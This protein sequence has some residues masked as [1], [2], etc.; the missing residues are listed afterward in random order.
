MPL[1]MEVLRKEYKQP[2]T[3]QASVSSKIPYSAVIPFHLICD[4]SEGRSFHEYFALNAWQPFQT[5]KC[6]FVAH[7]QILQDSLS[8]LYH[9]LGS[10]KSVVKFVARRKI[11][12]IRITPETN[13]P[14]VT[15]GNPSY[16]FHSTTNTRS[17]PP[18]VT[19]NPQ[20]DANRKILQ[21][22]MKDRDWA[23]I[24]ETKFVACLRSGRIQPKARNADVILAGRILV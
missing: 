3:Q 12:R 16:Y 19:T 18:F 24:S 7:L 5:E 9:V 22:L 11:R 23:E 8:L 17:S 15:R 21:E 6:L 14:A 10:K 4:G 2:I 1:Q 20:L 13:Y